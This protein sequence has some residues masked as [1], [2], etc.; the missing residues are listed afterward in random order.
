MIAS[1][2]DP[3]PTVVGLLTLGKSPRTWVPPAYIQCLR[4]R[5][6]QWG[7]PVLDE[8]ELDGNPGGPC[9]AFTQQNFGKP[10]V[11]DY[12]NPVLASTLQALGFVQRIGFGIAEAR[13]SMDALRHR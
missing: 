5:G 12:R 3:T 10:G 1:V 2:D 7:D 6:L 9:G 13:R 11:S 4:I 8:A